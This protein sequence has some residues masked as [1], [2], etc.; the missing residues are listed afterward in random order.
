MRSYVY[1]WDQR[2]YIDDNGPSHLLPDDFW[3]NA[4]VKI[5]PITLSKK[6]IAFNKSMIL[7][8]SKFATQDELDDL[9]NHKSKL[10]RCHVVTN[11]NTSYETIMKLLSTDPDLENA[12]KLNLAQNTKTP[13]EMLEKL[14]IHPDVKIRKLCARNNISK[15]LLYKMSIYDSD[16]EVRKLCKIVIME[17]RIK[18]LELLK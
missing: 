16:V 4:P 12:A 3:D 11:L 10:V 8:N 2:F 17:R 13:I 7:A 1:F 15:E 18:F 14:A 9:S 6:K 5:K